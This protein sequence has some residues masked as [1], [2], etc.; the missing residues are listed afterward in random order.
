MAHEE[1]G[2]TWRYLAIGAI[3]VVFSLTGYLVGN[4]ISHIADRLAS[5][6]QILDSRASLAPR[7]D[8]VERIQAD[9][10][11]RIRTVEQ[12]H[13]KREQRR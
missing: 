13:W 8:A 4:L 2:P 9:Q 12:D 7:L 11:N 1:N 10:E 6:Q 3:S 5:I